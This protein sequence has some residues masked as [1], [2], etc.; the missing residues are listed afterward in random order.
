MVSRRPP[1]G[2]TNFETRLT[3]ASWWVFNP[4][5][6]VAAAFLR[7][8]WGSAGHCVLSVTRIEV[9]DVLVVTSCRRPGRAGWVRIWGSFGQMWPL[10][11]TRLYWPSAYFAYDQRRC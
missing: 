10:S 4:P 7:A 9:C 8:V 3:P 5:R 6:G 1:E 2:K 11:S